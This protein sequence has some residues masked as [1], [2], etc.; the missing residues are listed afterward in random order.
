MNKIDGRVVKTSEGNQT[1]ETENATIQRFSPPFQIG[2]LKLISN[3]LLTSLLFM[4]GVF[5][6]LIGISSP[7]YG[8][9]VFG[10]IAILLSLFGSGFSVSEL[11][12]IFIGIG[13]VSISS[14][15][16]VRRRIKRKKRR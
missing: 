8:S 14:V 9:E 11:S 2:L 7:G 10:V 1:L 6:L 3:P 5:A 4:L 16:V 15:Y 12:L 13:A